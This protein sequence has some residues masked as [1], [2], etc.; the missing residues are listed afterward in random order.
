MDCK[1]KSCNDG[2]VWGLGTA[3]GAVCVAPEQVRGG[4][5]DGRH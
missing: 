4:E 5:F 1:I 2:G 3:M